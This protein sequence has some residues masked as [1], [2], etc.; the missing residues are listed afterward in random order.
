WGITG[1]VLL[2]LLRWLA[3]QPDGSL[4]FALSVYFVNFA[5]PLGF[6]VLNGYF[7]A[8][9]ASLAMGTMPWL[10]LGGSLRAHKSSPKLSPKTRCEGTVGARRG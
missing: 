7:I 10:L 6:C 4:K 8:V 1:F 5:L 9:F 2:A 3:P